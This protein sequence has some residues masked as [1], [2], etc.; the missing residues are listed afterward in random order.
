LWDLVK[1]SVAGSS[2][3]LLVDEVDNKKDEMMMIIQMGQ[4]IILATYIHNKNMK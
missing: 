2:I 4:D 3:N 1:T